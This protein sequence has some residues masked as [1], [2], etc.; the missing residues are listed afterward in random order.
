MMESSVLLIAAIFLPLISAALINLFSEKPKFREG[1]AIAVATLLCTVIYELYSRFTGGQTI[2]AHLFEIFPGIPIAFKLEP[3]GLIYAG[4]ASFLWLISI[5]YSIGYISGVKEKNQ[6]RF[7]IFFSIAICCSLGIAFA[8][9]LATMFIFYE[10]LTLSTYPLVIHRSGVDSKKAG[11]R[12]L[13]YLIGASIILFLPAIIWVEHLS[14]SL[15]FTSGGLIAGTKISDTAIVFLLLLFAFG[16][17]KSALMPLHKWLPA[18]MVAPTPVSAL[19]HA[20]AVVKAGVFCITKVVFYIIGIDT[21]SAINESALNPQI[22]SYIAA[23]TLLLASTIAIF[24]DNLK[25]RLAYSTIAQLSYVV[26]AA[27]IFSL[28]AIIAAALHIVAHAVGKITLFFGSG[29][30][31]MASGKK[32]VSELDGIGRQMPVV[33]ICFFIASLSMIG[34]PF[35]AGGESKHF[36]EEAAKAA[37]KEWI[38]YALYISMALNA[39]YYLPISYR[40]F[41]KKPADD[42]KLKTPLSI[43]I[44]MIITTLLVVTYI[45]YIDILTNLLEKI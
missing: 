32:N 37:N 22:L 9:N 5:I 20:V 26:I 16:I 19:L 7:Y 13:G 11:R 18:A 41:C 27:S 4:I 3:L 14:G 35:L 21:L 12:Y 23:I 33:G 42:E 45:F 43:K 30:I 10:M 1:A 39:I 29:A 40:A 44:A 2:E 34:L 31:T 17:G 38:S 24:K 15:E 25:A 28:N 36:I 8:E 6:T